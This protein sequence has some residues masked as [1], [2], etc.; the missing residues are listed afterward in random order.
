MCEEYENILKC[1]EA[2]S[3]LKSN[4]KKS[5]LTGINLE[6]EDLMRLANI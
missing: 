2:I 6:N 3:R 4:L 1:F 5:S